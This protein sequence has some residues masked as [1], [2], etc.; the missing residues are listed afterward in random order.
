M[1]VS[2]AVNGNVFAAYPDQVFGPTLV[3]GDVVVLDNLLAHK[4]TG[5]AK[6]VGACEA[7][8]PYLP[9]YYPNFNPIELTFNKRKTWLRTGQ[10]RTREAREIDI[11]DACDWI[12]ELAA[13]NWF[14]HCGYHVH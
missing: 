6:R 11:Q 1:S 13:E 2:E 7:R 4:V 10:A 14:D 9:P 3:P 5:L 12:T 8:L